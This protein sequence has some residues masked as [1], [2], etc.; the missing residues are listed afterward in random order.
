MN[1]L[2]N[3]GVVSTTSGSTASVTSVKQLAM[4][5]RFLCAGRD[6]AVLGTKLLLPLIALVVCLSAL[7]QAQTFSPI[8]ALS[9]NKTFGGNDPL[10]QVIT[11]TSVG[12]SFDFNATASATTGGT[13][14]SITPSAFGCCTATPTSITVSVNPVVTLAAGTYTGQIVLKSNNNVA[15]LTIPVTLIVHAATN[16]YLDQIAGGLTFTLQTSG[17]T[18]PAQIVPIRNAGSGTLNWTATT[19]TADGGSWLK[20]SAASGTAPSSL[21]ASIQLSS[22][23]GIGLTAGTFTGQVVVQ[24]A[25]DAITV[26]ITVVVGSNVFAQVNP[27]EFDKVYAGANPVSQVIT[28]A[29]TGTQFAFNAVTLNSTGGNWL[30]ITPSAYGCCTATP[31]AITVTVNPSVT[32]AAGY[33]AAE[34]IVR[35]NVGDEALSIPVHLT[36]NPSTA[37]F[38]D[39]VAGA[40]NFSME[41]SGST[42]PAQALQIRNL[43]TGALAWAGSVSTAD[44]GT[45][46]SLSAA[47]GTAP[48]NIT[49]AVNPANLPGGGLLPGTFVGQV[50]LSSSAGRVTVPVSFT[51]GDAVFRQVNPLNFTKVF[52]GANPLPQ[53]ITIASTGADFAFNAVTVDSTGGS[54][55]QITPSVFGCCTATPQAITVTVNPSVTLAAGTYSAEIVVKANTGIESVTIPVTLTIEPATAS[56]FD[57][58][59]GQMTFS[60]Q[61][62]GADPPPQAIEIRNAGVGTLSWTASAST[63]DGGAWL[64]VSAASGTAPYVLAASVVPGNLPGGGLLAGTFTGE[65]ILDTAG[66]RVTIPVT[67]VVG[68][69]VFRQV[70]ALNFTKVA[71]GANP[72]PQFVEVEST[73]TNFAFNAVA[74]NANGGNWL[75]ISPSVYGCCTATPQVIT[76]TVNPAV[77]LAA[78]TYTA[79]IIVKANTGGQSVVV[80]VTLTIEPATVAFF[81]DVPGAISFFQVTGG[82]APGAQ[83]FQ[84]RNRGVGVLNWAAATTTADGG[85]WLS[86]SRASGTAPSTVSV[87]I[88]PANLPGL[89]LTPGIF[90]GQI[91]LQAAGDRETIPVTVVVGANVFVPLPAM[92]FSKAYG[93]SNPASQTISVQSSATNFTFSGV[94]YSGNG[95][96]WL[97]IAPTSYGCCTGTPFTVTVSA[98]PA[99]TL[100]A[101]AYAA[102]IFLRSN[103]G[104]MGMVV[105]V[106]LT[107]N[108]ATAAAAPTFDRPTGDYWPSTTLTM[109]D[110]TIASGIYYTTDGSTPT[111]ASKQYSGTLTITA[112]QTIKAIAAAPGFPNSAVTTATYTIAPIPATMLTP[113]PGSKMTGANA[114]FTWNTGLGV[115]QY[116]LYIGSTA[117]ASDIDLVNTGTATTTSV[118]NLPTNGETL[119]VTL[120]SLIGSTWTPKAY[121]YLASGTGTAATMTSPTPGTKLPSASATFTWTTGSGISQYSLYIG[122]TPGAHDIDFFSVGTATSKAVTNLPT[123]GATLYVTLYSLNGSTYLKNAYTY[124]AAGTGTAAAMTA[125]TPGSKMSSASATFTWTAGTGISQYT[126]YI[127]STPGAHDIDYVNAGTA[128]TKT[129]TNLPT[130]GGTLYITLY[131]LNG[132]T[133]LKNSYTYVAAGT[134]TAATMTSPTPGSKLSGASATFSWTTG[135]GINQYT[136]YIGTTAGAHDIDYLNAGLSTSKSVTNLPTNGATLYITLYSLNGNTYLKN[137]Y[138]YVAAGP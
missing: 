9:F 123:N 116:K 112:S 99:V 43:G 8:P 128:T 126:L 34:I 82:S 25:G 15:S 120:Y 132:S 23:P 47:S 115:S 122:T 81:D 37:A 124:I 41:T 111:P 52:G 69:A 19:S 38:F 135:V 78:G 91:I 59:P 102:E 89:G 6:R 61:T 108:S 39:D 56:F 109:T 63:S 60:M 1:K 77:T 68:D 7:V 121:T 85:N 96:N 129:V 87:S 113:A 51:V 24:T 11:V 42:P 22:L 13:W 138:T 54:W 16:T 88:N 71:G 75:T 27:L 79:E 117:G 64:K 73:G 65:I 21:S 32:L 55:L 29:S 12:S 35:S 97:V 49:L 18:P 103:A 95:G 33:Y 44:G 62:S 4:G 67:M 31:Q 107:V 110:P 94:A 76:A 130:N 14:L 17:K 58:L 46:L 127:G 50:I 125:P 74:V 93:G 104:D 119:Y 66:D 92:Q 28:V 84:V 100:A 40:L 106:T 20:I 26:P 118:T 3:Q 137:S 133:Y 48:S 80:P 134:G 114:T 57:T 136:L 5:R 70:N 45:W 10:P 72:L 90:N 53:V 36:I 2:A 30:T 98:N 101:G 86:I 131:S 83:A 105:P